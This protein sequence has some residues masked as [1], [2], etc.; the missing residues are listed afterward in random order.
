MKIDYR[1]LEPY[2]TNEQIKEYTKRAIAALQTLK[3]RNG[4]GNDFLGW[5]DLPSEYNNDFEN[6]MLEAVNKLKTLDAVVVVG[7]GGSYLGAKAVIDALTN[8][9]EK[10]SPEIIYA[11]NQ[12]SESYHKNLLNYLSKKQF[13]IVVISKSGT[14]TEPAIVFRMLRDLLVKNAGNCHN[15]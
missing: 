14:T 5:L 11:G 8:P 12:L 10:K 13:G 4:A 1:F 6:E 2:V 3:S 7:I 9:F 15:R